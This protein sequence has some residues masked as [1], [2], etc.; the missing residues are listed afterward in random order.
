MWTGA[1]LTELTETDD[2]THLLILQLADGRK[3]VEEPL[4][5]L[6]T[7]SLSNYNARNVQTLANVAG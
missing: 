6:L 5:K 4:T 7:L 1:E 3:T 2:A